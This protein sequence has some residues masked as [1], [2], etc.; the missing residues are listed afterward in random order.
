[1]KKPV[2][3]AF[4]A[5]LMLVD[6]GGSPEPAEAIGKR[7]RLFLGAL[8]GAAAVALLAPQFRPYAPVRGYY[9]YPGYSAR[10]PVACPGGF[11]AARPTRF[12]RWGRPTRWSKPRFVCPPP[13]YYWWHYRY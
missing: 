9:Y 2:M 12:D 11:W 8:F 10:F 6:N 5:A 7:E 13:G 1:M 4:A 3:L